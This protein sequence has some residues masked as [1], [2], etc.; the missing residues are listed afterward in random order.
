MNE[1]SKMNIEFVRAGAGSGKTYYLTQLLAGRLE[2]KTARASAV[3]ATTFTVKAAT[4]LRERARDTLLK[5]GNLDLAA[6]IGQA[7]IGTINSVCG[8]LIQR[9]CF[10]L[11]VSP[12]Q[13]ILDEQQTLRVASVALE[14]AQTPQEIRSLIEVARRLDIG[15]GDFSSKGG[16]EQKLEQ[17][18]MKTLRELMAAARENNLQPEQLAAMGAQNAD[19]MLS[20]WPAIVEG[21]T[22]A[23]DAELENLIPQLEAAMNKGKLTDVLKKAFNRCRDS[24][25]QLRE[26]RMS[27]SSWAAL[28]KLNAG[29]PQRPIVEAL[30]D[31]AKRHGSHPQFHADVRLYLDLMFGI[32]S[33]GLAAFELAKREM[34]VVDFTDQE[35][36]LL[37]GL[38]HSKVMQQALR[39]ELDLVLVDEFQDTNPLQLAIF[40]ELAKLAKSSVWVGDRKQAIYGFRGTDSTLIQQVLD[41]VEGWGG[42][43]G[44]ALTDSW[45]S[46]P[47]LVKLVNEAFVAAFD[48]TPAADV[49]LTPVRDA[50]VGSTDL[51][52]WTFEIPPGKR[53]LDVTGLGPALA[54]LLQSDMQVFD[55]ETKALRR[56]QLG[57][58]AVLC[59]TKSTIKN[60]VGALG[61]W[62]IPVAA[63][64]PGLLA[65][66]EAQLVVACLRRFHDPGD[67]VASAVITGLTQALE[68][69]QWLHDRLSFLSDAKRNEHGDWEPRLSSWKV[70]GEGALPLL[71]RLDGLRDRL[72]S[73]TPF[74]ALRLAKAE[75]GVAN[76]CYSWSIDKRAAQ[77][78][79]ANVEKLLSLGQQYEEECLSS[80]RPGTLNGLL[81]WLQKLDA[82][83]KDGRAAASH[84]AV[85]VMTFHGSKGLEWPVVVVVGLDHE[86]KTDLWQVRARTEGKFDASAPLSNRFVHYWPYPYGASKSDESAIAEATGTGQV[87]ANA[88]L[89]EN[90][91][92]LY[93]SLTR[94][95][96]QI[97][98]VSRPGSS[99]GE[100]PLSWLNEA[101]A[102]KTFWPGTVRRAI[103]GVEVVCTAADWAVAQ[104]HVEPPEKVREV[105]RFYPLR[106]PVEHPP[107]WVRPSTVHVGGYR[108]ETIEAIGS[109]I[110][111]RPHTDFT[112]LGSALHNCI[113]CATADRDLGISLE[114][115]TDILLRWG[116]GSAIEPQ[117][118]LDQ[119]NAFSLWWNAR[120]PQAAAISEVPFE[121][122]RA[123]GSV[124]RGQIDLLLS[125]DGGRILFDHKSDPRGVGADD[126]LASTHGG[127]LAEY[128]KAIE[129][130][131]G[132]PVLERWLFLPVSA[133]AVRIV[134]A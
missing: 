87:M 57:D 43:V 13:Q 49:A 119:V 31:T 63:E 121:A 47:A 80:G 98:L 108:V 81:L 111:V 93:V 69:E 9:F 20:C 83:A 74:E 128:A 35:V 90:R 3:L 21:L 45:R 42:K 105:Q 46:T 18:V 130:A 44:A 17:A 32:A 129:A 48:P 33:R 89:E 75:S 132:E 7:R 36:L 84:G 115:V 100:L 107:L 124:A 134:E 114:E 94:A 4:E 55:K 24:R 50:I 127:Q 133:Q 2:D 11:G 78:R 96:D 14:S 30:Q 99:T 25:Q 65:T 61:R 40:I 82:D 10:E 113:A 26:G 72:L 88:A 122:K 56:V 70:A 41:S 51:Q 39:E 67:T 95:R 66:P 68:P 15:Q 126:R 103:D 1:A 71:T 106:A 5:K 112:L 53:V 37:R 116:V 79:I 97:I 86:Y 28:A 54:Q 8:Q 109:R 131:S 58:I 23:L 120:W 118:A 16:R 19:A 29:V 62:G 12:D 117:A 123:D 59:R 34:G 125:V 102:A 91:R 85:E 64:R 104:T 60:V 6:A 77:V 52:T 22:E 27:W 73:L 110:K 38:K 76:L 101:N 92:L